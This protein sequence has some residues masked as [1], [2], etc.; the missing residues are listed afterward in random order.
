MSS[1]FNYGS[2]HLTVSTAIAIASGKIKGVLSD[3]VIKRIK[4]SQQAVQQIVDKGS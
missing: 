3:I 1:I 4:E 2:D